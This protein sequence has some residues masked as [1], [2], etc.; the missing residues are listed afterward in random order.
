MSREN[1]RSIGAIMGL[2]VGILLML[3]LRQGGVIPGAIFGAGGALIGGI[4][5]ERVHAIVNGK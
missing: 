1:Y 2:V 4:L 3:G 5:G